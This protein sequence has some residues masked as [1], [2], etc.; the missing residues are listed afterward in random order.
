M[1]QSLKYGLFLVLALLIHIASSEATGGISKVPSPTYRQSVCCVS[2]DRPVRNAIERLYNFYS[3]QPCD[4][5]H[6]DV[7]HV[8]ADKSILLLI[9]YLREYK[10]PQSLSR[11]HSLHIADYFYD[12]ITHYIYGLRKIVI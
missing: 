11:T 3:T 6:A 12:P 7:T 2:Q 4:M 8:P 1:K 5:S 10:S 9:T